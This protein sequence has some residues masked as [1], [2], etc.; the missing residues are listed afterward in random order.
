ML[1][2]EVLICGTGLAALTP[3]AS[4]QATEI[5]PTVIR[6][7]SG[8]AVQF[9]EDPRVESFFDAIQRHDTNTVFQMLDADTNLVHALYYGRRPLHVA[10]QKGCAAIVSRLLRSGAAIDEE[11]DSLDTSNAQLTALAISV[12]YNQPTVCRLL[13]DAGAN[14]NLGYYNGGGALHLAFLYKRTEMVGWLLAHGANPFLEN[15]FPYNQNT[16]MDLAITHGGGQWVPR[17]LSLMDRFNTLPARTNQPA[18]RFGFPSRAIRKTAS[19]VFAER[20][21]G[22]LAAAAQHGELEAVK[23]LLE[24]HV[25]ASTN[26]PGSLS[27]LQAFALAESS[28]EKNEGFDRERWLKIRDL[29]IQHGANYDAFAATALGD[30]E[31]ARQLV[32]ANPEVASARDREQQTPLHWA[33]QTDRLPLGAFWMASG[34]PLGATNSAGQTAL[35]LAAK[36][37]KADFVK[38]LLSKQAPT[39]IRDT[40]GW[41]ALDAAIQAK[42]P[43]SI[44]LLLSDKTSPSHP[45]RGLATPLHAAAASGNVGAVAAL[46]ETQTDLEA[47]N[48]LGLT[49]LQVAV[50]QGHLAAA[51]LLVDKGAD[52]H[53]RDPEGNGLLHQILLQERL[54]IYDR[55]PT[56]WLERAAKDPNKDLYVQYLTVGQYE[57]GPNPLLQ[58][59]SF[60]LAS[61]VNASAK[62]KAGD[63]PMQLIAD[64]KTGRGVFFF[65][66]DREKLLQLLSTRGG[67]VDARDADGNTALHRLCTGYYDVEKVDSMASLIA[68]GADVNATNNMG[69]TPLHVA[70]QKIGGW[71]HNDPPVNEPFQLLVYKKAAVNVRDNQGRTPLH[72]LLISDSSFKDEAARLLIAAGANPNLQDNEGMTPLHLLASSGLAFRE[73][74]VQCVLEAGANPNIQ[75]KKGRTPAHLFL[76]GAWPWKSAGACL[77]ELAAARADFSIKDNQGKTPLHYL[78]AL[79]GQSPMFFIRGIDRIFVDAKVDFQAKDNDGNTPAAIAA[80]AGTKDVFNWLVKQGASPGATNNPGKP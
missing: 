18:S 48:E 57:Q 79:G 27:V 55:P 7:P 19:Q 76:M 13:L 80:K 33:V 65:D 4:G 62:N 44:H 67:N 42:Q 25:S 39:G 47:R 32:A 77:K 34:T 20:S 59:T 38:L 43:D 1:F 11:S 60:L 53:V 3:S 63:T 8:A 35:H 31:R 30:E 41:T 70:A 66:D 74:V 22:W 15:S 72:V 26:A 12:W 75:D 9:S 37:G 52:V 36:G 23:A 61:G 69:Q 6:T 50:I 2:L 54:I 49:P 56:K 58:A 73:S 21:P 45:E 17:M 14:P 5:P 68:S 24:A 71:D 29:L 51:A 46:T 10:S 28:A 78:A 16:P 64:L 40:N